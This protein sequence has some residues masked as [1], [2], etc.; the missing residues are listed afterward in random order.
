MGNQQTQA[1]FVQTLSFYGKEVKAIYDDFAQIIEDNKELTYQN[2]WGE[3]LHLNER[4][5]RGLMPQSWISSLTR[6][7]GKDGS[8]RHNI[9][10]EKVLGLD[11]MVSYLRL[12]DRTEVFPLPL[13]GYPLANK[14]K[15]CS[16]NTHGCLRISCRVCSRWWRNANLN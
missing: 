13:E 11:L 6:N 1:R 3:T 14:G 15:K 16:G 8:K 5:L 12:Y 10:D 9:T 4:S 2:K 7:S